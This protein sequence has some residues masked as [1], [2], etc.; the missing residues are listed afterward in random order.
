MVR[1]VDIITTL[2]KNLFVDLQFSSHNTW[3]LIYNLSLN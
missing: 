1:Y 3:H 2:S